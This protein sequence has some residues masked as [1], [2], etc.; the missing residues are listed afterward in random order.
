MAAGLALS[1]ARMRRVEGLAPALESRVHAVYRGIGPHTKYDRI[2]AFACCRYRNRNGFSTNP[3][4]PL[5]P[6]GEGARGSYAKSFSVKEGLVVDQT[7]SQL[8]H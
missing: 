7:R 6:P 5:P 2:N 3:N 4:M 8:A 1:K